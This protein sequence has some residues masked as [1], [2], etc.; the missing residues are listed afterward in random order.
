MANVRTFFFVPVGL[1]GMGK[2]TLS[3]NFRS[4]CQ[5][6]FYSQ[7]IE[8]QEN[9]NPNIQPDQ[10]PYGQLLLDFQKVSYDGL[11]RKHQEEY[12][13]KFP[14]EEFHRVIDIIRDFAD[15]EYLDIITD[16]LKHLG[17]KRIRNLVYLDRNNT[18]D[19]WNDITSTIRSHDKSS[20]A[21]IIALMPC[22]GD[23]DM[24]TYQIPNPLSPEFVFECI[25]RIYN[26]KEH[27]C[28]SSANKDKVIDV[29]IKFTK[30]Y[31]GANFRDQ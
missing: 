4:A 12:L 10:Y 6:F 15:K 11:L 24:N 26:R 7:I 21:R 13:A 1:P 8:D 27:S 3:K 18:S 28:L 31:D 5:K 9:T 30:L 17:D 22:M 29:L 23:F 19:I 16:K 14:D 25:K 2:T 20:E